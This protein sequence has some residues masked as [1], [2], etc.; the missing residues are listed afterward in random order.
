MGKIQVEEV[1]EAGQHD[2]QKFLHRVSMR[3]TEAWREYLRSRGQSPYPPHAASS[4]PIDRIE[5]RFYLRG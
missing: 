2:E 5:L 4:E 3:A 1:I